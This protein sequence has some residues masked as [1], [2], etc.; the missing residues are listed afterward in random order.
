VN[1]SNY[2]DLARAKKLA[3]T[4][5][6]RVRNLAREYAAEALLSEDH[7]DW[8]DGKGVTTYADKKEFM[9]ELARIAGRIRK[10]I[11]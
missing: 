9:T 11:N 10:T 3:D 6:R 5:R 7:P 8:M 4:A 1:R 2:R